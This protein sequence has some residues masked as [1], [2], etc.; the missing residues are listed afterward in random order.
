M[1]VPPGFKPPTRSS[2]N[3]KI[4]SSHGKALIQLFY[5]VIT[6]LTTINGRF[7]NIKI[8]ENLPVRKA[9]D[10]LYLTTSYGYLY[11]Q[12]HDISDFSDYC[13]IEFSIN[14]QIR[15]K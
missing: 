3:L 6:K 7:L 5:T 13:A 4:L 8:S 11:L 12:V 15:E 2:Q 14:A 1:G 10:P 9:R